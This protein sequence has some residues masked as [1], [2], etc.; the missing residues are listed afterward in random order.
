MKDVIYCSDAEFCPIREECFRSMAET[1]TKHSYAKFYEEYILS[2]SK[3]KCPHFIN[4]I[5][6][7]MITKGYQKKQ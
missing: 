1:K 2:C 4:K 6:Q 5:P 7:F 3:E